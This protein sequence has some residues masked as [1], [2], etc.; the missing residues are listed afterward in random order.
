MTMLRVDFENCNLR[1]PFIT[2][3][4]LNSFPQPEPFNYK[5]I[6]LSHSGWLSYKKRGIIPVRNDASYDA[7]LTSSSHWMHSARKMSQS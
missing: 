4:I 3:K 2:S 1:S 5:R 6:F 7:T